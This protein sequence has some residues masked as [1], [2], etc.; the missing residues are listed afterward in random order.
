MKKA[1]NCNFAASFFNYVVS[2]IAKLR[3]ASD[4]SREFKNVFVIFNSLHMLTYTYLHVHKQTSQLILVV[5]NPN[6]AVLCSISSYHLSLVKTKFRYSW[7]LPQLYYAF[8]EW[9]S[10]QPVYWIIEKS[11]TFLKNNLGLNLLI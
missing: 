6:I 9:I 5:P 11:I 7:Q 2:L 3:E 8:D 4:K 10:V 1:I